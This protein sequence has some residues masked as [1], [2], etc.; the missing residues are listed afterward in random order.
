MTIWH[1]RKHK[2]LACIRNNTLWSFIQANKILQ[3]KAQTSRKHMEWYTMESYTSKWIG[4]IES[5][6]CK[7]SYGM[8]H[9]RVIY[10]EMKRHNRKHKMQACIWNDT[11]RSHTQANEMVQWKAQMSSMHMEWYTWNEPTSQW[12]DT[13]E[14]TKILQAYGMIHN[15]VIYKQIKWHNR[16]HKHLACTWND[17]QTSHIQLNEMTQ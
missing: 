14:S 8:I 13:I 10:K 12:N 5:A 11:Q 17:I 2:C 3:T 4:T 15:E 9:N 6:K 16:K 1:N 7:H